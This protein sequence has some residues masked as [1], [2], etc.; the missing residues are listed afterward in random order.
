[1]I[2]ELKREQYLN[3]QAWMITDLEL[4]GNDLI[5]YAII[6]GFSQ[7][8]DNLFMGN[9]SYLAA[10]CRCSERSIQRNINNLME[11]GLIGN[12]DI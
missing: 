1:M 7:D 4:T 5:V 12:R 10:W 6:Y 2:Y 3:I 9:R 8:G 11:R